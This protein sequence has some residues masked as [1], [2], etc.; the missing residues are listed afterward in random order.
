MAR[1]LNNW[2]GQSGVMRRAGGISH[3]GSEMTEYVIREIG[4]ADRLSIGACANETE[5]VQLITED[6]RAK[7]RTRNSADHKSSNTIQ[8]PVGCW[9]AARAMG[10][11]SS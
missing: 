8:N 9:Q 2:K 6:S 11:A 3:P 1:R 10:L 5:A 7:A 4:H